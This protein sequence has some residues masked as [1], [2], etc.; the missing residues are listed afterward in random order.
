MIRRR[1]TGETA[2]RSFVL[3]ADIED[4]AHAGGVIAQYAQ[5]AFFLGTQISRHQ[6]VA[7]GRNASWSRPWM[8]RPA[9]FA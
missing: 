3:D 1:R 2:A 8:L 5:R 9:P 6:F 7:A 4:S